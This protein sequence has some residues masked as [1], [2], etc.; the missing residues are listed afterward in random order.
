MK[1]G[2]H[3]FSAV[4]L[5]L[6]ALFGGVWFRLMEDGPFWY[7]FWL[8]A[9]TFGAITVFRAFQFSRR[10]GWSRILFVGMT[11]VTL[12]IALLGLFRLT[13]L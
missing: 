4:M 7:G 3:Y 5:G 1:I 9:G 12:C 10:D 13:A 11:I 2:W 8:F 6:A